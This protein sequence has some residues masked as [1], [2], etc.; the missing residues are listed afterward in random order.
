MSVPVQVAAMGQQLKAEMDRTLNPYDAA[1]VAAWSRAWRQLEPEFLDALE[2]VM[3]RNRTGRVRPSKFN[4]SRKL[5]A[6]LA[7]AHE[8]VEE[9]LGD[10]GIEVAQHLP[11]A[12]AAA[13]QGTQAMAAAQLPPNS[14]PG[15]V[16]VQLK[17]VNP[18]LDSIVARTLE[19]I[20]AQHLALP[21]DVEQAMRDEL[22]RGVAVGENPRA[23]AQRI[24]RR[25]RTRF[26]GGLPRATTIAHTEMLD[27][28]R[29]AS[30]EWMRANRDVVQ[31][32]VW[33]ASLDS[34]C[35]PACVAMHGREF[36]IDDPPPQDH[37]R[38]RCIALPQT[39]T[40]AEL[41]YT[42]VPETRA[43]MQT[44]E[45][46]YAEQS[47][48]TQRQMLG[49][50]VAD[51]YNAGRITWADIARTRENRGWRDSITPIRIKDLPPIKGE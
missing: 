36:S 45:D 48:E 47:L 1:L 20:T 15:A 40:W 35:C 50:K 24:V 49:A 29:N 22:I 2:D 9:I 10:Y 33:E 5:A 11:D 38:G 8:R 31:S 37:H 21:G 4:R 3:T 17:H 18:Q 27:A 30:R 7:H 26:N 39:K 14:G 44:G 42:G 16:T 32:W 6:A 12:V 46:W 43:V 23:V 41:G 19:R 28:N 51:A 25:T 34:R 13:V